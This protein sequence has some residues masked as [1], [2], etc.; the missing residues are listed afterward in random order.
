MDDKVEVAEDEVAVEPIVQEVLQQPPADPEVVVGLETT[1]APT[2]ENA[3]EATSTTPPA[4]AAPVD[5]ATP[6]E[7]APTQPAPEQ[8]VEAA[9]DPG[10]VVKAEEESHAASTVAGDA[11]AK[12][13]VAATPP[14]NDAPKKA[15]RK[16]TRKRV[17]R[18]GK[19]EPRKIAKIEASSTDASETAGGGDVVIDGTNGSVPQPEGTGQT[20][21]VLSKHDEK[22][23]NM[24]NRLLEFK[25][26]N[27]HTLVPQCYHDDPRLGR[28]VHYQRV[29]YWIYQEAG[30]GKIT[31]ERIGRLESIGFEWDPQKAQ[32]NLMFDRLVKFKEE[33]GHC[34]VPK[35]YPKDTELANWVRNQR[36]EQANY[37]KNKKSRMTQE[38]YEKLGGLGFRWSTSIAKKGSGRKPASPAPSSSAAEPPAAPSAGVVAADAKEDSAEKAVEEAVAVAIEIGEDTTRD[39][40]AK[41]E[42]AEERE[43]QAVIQI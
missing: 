9:S 39:T 1:E 17:R 40:T 27:N 34:K 26:A 29:E 31:P 25:K 14:A 11:A 30:N 20:R 32:W 18:V 24:F 38:R 42:E 8:S 13:D 2:V 5:A 37:K 16:E 35:G 28:W 23:N 7:T 10:D 15:K 19:S 36:L 21:R 6:A 3:S 41:Q 33:N 43:D 12:P 4:D 22:W